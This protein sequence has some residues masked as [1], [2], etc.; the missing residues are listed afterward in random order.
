MNGCNILVFPMIDFF[1]RFVVFSFLSHVKTRIIYIVTFPYRHADSYLSVFAT[2][3]NGKRIV[4]SF[5]KCTPIKMIVTLRRCEMAPIYLSGRFRYD[6]YT[7]LIYSL[8]A[9]RPFQLQQHTIFTLARLAKLAYFNCPP[10]TWW[11]KLRR[12]NF[13][14]DNCQF[15]G[16]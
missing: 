16:I 12:G 3:R 6:P 1:I 13:D 10:R 8:N 7:I 2:V 11:F 14:D 5:E 15:V 4:R 9:T